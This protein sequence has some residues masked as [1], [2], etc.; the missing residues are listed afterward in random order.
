MKQ[1]IGSIPLFFLLVLTECG[2]LNFVDAGDASAGM[3]T[4][5][6][7]AEWH[8]VNLLA[9]AKDFR[10]DA[11]PKYAVST[12]RELLKQFPDTEAAVEA[13]QMLGEIEYHQADRGNSE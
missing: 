2:G 3:L 12:L 11:H 9:S 5:E 8:A 7:I 1:L 6:E 4:Q 13:K 10:K